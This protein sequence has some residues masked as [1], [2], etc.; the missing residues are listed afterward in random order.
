M[1]QQT[2]TETSS[3]RKISDDPVALVSR[4]GKTTEQQAS[5]P[6]FVVDDTFF[7]SRTPKST[8]W[9]V[10]WSDLMMT[11]FILFLTLFVYQLA[12]RE[13]LSEESPEIVAGATMPV[14]QSPAPTLPFH[15]ISPA[16]SNTQSVQVKKAVPI[17]PV[18]LKK[19]GQHSDTREKIADKDIDAIFE[20]KKFQKKKTIENAAMNKDGRPS[21]E[22]GLNPQKSPQSATP[23]ETII[24]RMYDLSKITVADEKLE[25]FASVELIPDKTMRIVLT[26]DLLFPSGRAELTREAKTSLR[27]LIPI[28]R[29]TPYMINVIGHTD[30]M[31]MHSEKFSSNW[32]LSTA[33]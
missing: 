27:K 8:H 3:I 7:R 9:S 17:P 29:R 12:H 4:I 15:P 30:S 19:G 24:T 14:P 22:Q 21:M 1:E 11:M 25:K 26:G 6:V 28:I 13:F 33:R 32:E 23:A 31:P 2:P 20:G 18:P 16:I 10:A 5:H